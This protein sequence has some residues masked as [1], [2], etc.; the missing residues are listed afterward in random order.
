MIYR[1]NNFEKE[2]FL[3]T[4][5]TSGKLKVQWNDLISI[6]SGKYKKEVQTKGID[7][8][9][10]SRTKY[11]E[12]LELIVNDVS[13][14]LQDFLEIQIKKKKFNK[15]IYCHKN[16]HLTISFDIDKLTT[17]DRTSSFMVQLLIILKSVGMTTW[18]VSGNNDV[19][20]SKK[21]LVDTGVGEYI[22][23]YYNKTD[24]LK[25]NLKSDIHFINQKD[26]LFFSK[27]ETLVSNSI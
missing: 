13:K 5:E 22:D 15:I 20:N 11:T 7:L 1:I 10:I 8:K 23:K 12:K 9:I 17:G 21:M 16:I 26:T 3:R 6:L 4:G 27:Y 19:V 2:H 24:L 25:K 18:V 14:E